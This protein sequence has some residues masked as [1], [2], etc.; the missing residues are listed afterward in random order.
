MVEVK[1]ASFSPAGSSPI[2]RGPNTPKA[3]AARAQST[4]S[5]WCFSGQWFTVTGLPDPLFVDLKLI[6][7]KLKV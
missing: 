2:T 7:L 3:I 4:P 1:V 5:E 6:F